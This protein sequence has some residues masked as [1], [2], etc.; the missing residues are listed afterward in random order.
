MKKND[1]TDPKDLAELGVSSDSSLSGA[2]ISDPGDLAEIN[3]NASNI[4]SKASVASR[5]YTPALW[6]GGSML[7]G[8]AS[9]G[10]AGTALGPWGTVGG[11]I[12]GGAAGLLAAHG[13]DAVTGVSKPNT[14]IGDAVTSTNNALTESG[15]AEIGG[16]LISM[17]GKGLY[18]GLAP[19]AKQ[20]WDYAKGRGIPLTLDQISNNSLVKFLGSAFRAL[21]F[22]KS[23]A[24]DADAKT[25]SA[26]IGEHNDLLQSGGA[27]DTVK[28]K[29]MQIKKAL[30]EAIF[31][32]SNEIGAK[33]EQLAN[34]ILAKH[35]SP[36]T[37]NELS[38]GEQ[39]QQAK[40]SEM[41]RNHEKNMW[42]SLPIDHEQQFNFHEHV[43]SHA[44]SVLDSMAPFSNIPGSGPLINDL[45]K[46][47]GTDIKENFIK[48]AQDIINRHYQSFQDNFGRPVSSNVDIKKAIDDNLLS[49]H[50]IN[51]NN[52]E[53]SPK[54]NDLLNDR[55]MTFDQL[56]QMRSK[57]LQMS[58]N[59]NPSSGFANGA[60]PGFATDLSRKWGDYAKSID[61]AMANGLED[62]PDALDSLNAARAWSSFK[63]KE[64]NR[65][66]FTNI[67]GQQ[68]PEKIYPTIMQPGNITP[69][70]DV[71]RAWGEDSPTWKNYQDR[72][73]RG[74]LDT[75]QLSPEYLQS[76][77]DKWGKSTVDQI[78][79]PKAQ[80]DWYA[81]PGQLKDIGEST[82]AGSRLAENKIFQKI[83]NSESGSS[84]ISTIAGNSLTNDQKFSRI[85]SLSK[86]LDSVGENGKEL[87]GQA[88]LADIIKTNP[89][90]MPSGSA[91]N[92]LRKSY[93]DEFV[94]WL[95][96]K[97]MQQK[98]DGYV[99]TLKNV[100]SNTGALTNL[101]RTS[102]S[103]FA[104]K[105]L[106]RMITNPISSTTLGGG[107]WGL[108][109]AFYYE[110]F[111]NAVMDGFLSNPTS[112]AFASQAPK[113]FGYLIGGDS[114]DKKED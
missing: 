68:N 90:G 79:S 87:V 104:G 99:N 81:L 91:S 48:E 30:S 109:H 33:Q 107:A 84:V 74:A 35:G 27:A 5:S 1:I 41:L 60:V 105:M 64:I 25:I 65:D 92:R 28:E 23:V 32:N 56:K 24:E 46:A 58:R 72:W 54:L 75:D 69:I 47:A 22:S 45:R 31:K 73:L 19:E 6:A 10:E 16:N 52:I 76:I 43:G 110:P 102:P 106:M 103:G 98:L 82:A 44:A 70:M 88:V 37:Y 71:K 42:E 4:E 36:F 20:M 13:V 3:S 40:Y 7:G 111:T 113:L 55:T 14:G 94:N 114:K 18:E 101:S 51:P 11:A 86:A 15:E 85:Q 63:N 39:A 9:G 8:I 53:Q 62:N 57:A 17:A 89:Q 112:S 2:P 61:N 93:G 100:S 67:L 66:T 26:L 49:S 12:L 38:M 83:M 80:A 21:P 59:L 96:P 78:L 50:G 29:G 77:N 108:A 95:F 97:E 34:E